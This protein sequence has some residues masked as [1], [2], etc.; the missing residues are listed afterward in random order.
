MASTEKRV[1]H[2]EEILSNGYHFTALKGEAARTIKLP[3]T[4]KAAKKKAVKKAAK[5]RGS[6]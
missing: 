2:I 4:K 6:R 3:T 5:K 1:E